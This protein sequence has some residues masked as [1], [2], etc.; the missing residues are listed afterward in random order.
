MHNEHIYGF[1]ESNNPPIWK[2][3]SMRRHRM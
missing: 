1:R 2:V 3:Y